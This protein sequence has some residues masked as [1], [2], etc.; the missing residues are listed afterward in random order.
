MKRAF[1][2]IL[3]VSIASI[4]AISWAVNHHSAIKFASLGDRIP[5]GE[6]RSWIFVDGDFTSN[7]HRERVSFHWTGRNSLE[8]LLDHDARWECQQQQ[9]AN[10]SCESPQLLRF[11]TDA[12]IADYKKTWASAQ[13]KADPLDALIQISDNPIDR[14]E[15]WAK[16]DILKSDE[17][18]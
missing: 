4:A 13:A 16:R 18:H 8:F 10:V 5:S 3:F 14:R 2:I 11:C 9:G 17:P 6:Y 15:C 12:E 7:A 1:L